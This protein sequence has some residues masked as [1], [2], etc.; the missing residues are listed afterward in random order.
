M[1]VV[2]FCILLTHCIYVRRSVPH[3][4]HALYLCASFCS[5]FCS[6][7]V[8]MWVARFCILL[9][10]CV[11][12]VVLLCI[13][14]TQ[15][16]YVCRTFLTTS[17]HY[18]LKIFDLTLIYWSLWWDRLCSLWS[19][20]GM[21]LSWKSSNGYVQWRNQVQTFSVF[22]S[23][24]ISSLPDRS[25]LSVVFCITVTRLMVCSKIRWKRKSVPNVLI[26]T[27][28]GVLMLYFLHFKCPNRTQLN[29]V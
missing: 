12:Y 22:K 28:A 4:A 15:C 8:F 3:F 9:T 29:I 24:K 16:I 14:L 20:N 26:S 17:A 25:L 2:L 13:S 11:M 7:I 19:K 27:W 5:A 1:W 18:S 6:R 10:Q 21:L 23:T